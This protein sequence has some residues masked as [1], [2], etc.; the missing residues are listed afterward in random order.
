MKSL[1][2]VLATLLSATANANTILKCGIANADDARTLVLSDSNG[3]YVL[4]VI[5]PTALQPTSELFLEPSTVKQGPHL[6]AVD[7]WE[8]RVG[9][10]TLTAI[11]NV[12]SSNTQELK[13]VSDYGRDQIRTNRGLKQFA[14]LSQAGF[15]WMCKR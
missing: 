12:G 15:M 8:S 3:G 4:Q 13:L 1:I 6:I 14:A 2:L 5:D 11:F 7:T 9:G 10:L